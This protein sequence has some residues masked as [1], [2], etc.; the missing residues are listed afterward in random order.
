[1]WVPVLLW[2]GLGLVVL[3]VGAAIR[4]ELARRRRAEDG[5]LSDEAMLRIERVGTLEIEESERLDLPEIHRQEQRFWDQS[6][7]EPESL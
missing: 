3:G 6:W 7:D 5:H 1:M 4:I 2:S